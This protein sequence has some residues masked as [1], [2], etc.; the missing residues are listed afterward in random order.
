MHFYDP[1]NKQPTRAKTGARVADEQAGFSLLWLLGVK[2]HLET[3][4]N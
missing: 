1:F 4:L 3:M 2:N